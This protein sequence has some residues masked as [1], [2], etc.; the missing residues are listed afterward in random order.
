MKIVLGGSRH[1]EY[2]PNEV[3]EKLDGWIAQDVQ[4]LVGDAPGSDRAFQSFL[5]MRKYP[6]VLVLSSAG[7][8]RNNLGNWPTELVESGL[9]SKSHSVHAFKDRKMTAISDFGL[10][11]WDC[12]SAGTLSNVI[13]LLKQGKECALWIA[14]DSELCNFDNYD[15]LNRWLD[16]Y[17]DVKLEAESRLAKFAKREAKKQIENNQ[18]TL[19][20]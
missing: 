10:M 14:P 7:M 16:K 20:S 19:F 8:I 9:K 2:I 11:I 1:L 3:A 15:S 13:D 4:F 18:E 6:N 5:Q 17:P 12:E